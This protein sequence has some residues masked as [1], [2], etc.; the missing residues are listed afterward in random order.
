MSDSTSSSYCTYRTCPLG[1]KTQGSYF[2]ICSK[3]KCEDKLV[4]DVIGFDL[5]LLCT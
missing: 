3:Q 4:E 5:K 2:G 1:N